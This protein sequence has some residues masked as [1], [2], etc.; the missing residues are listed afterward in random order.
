MYELRSLQG[1]NQRFIENCETKSQ[2]GREEKGSGKDKQIQ[3][4]L[5]RLAQYSAIYEGS[6]SATFEET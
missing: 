4:E 3:D 2:L 1:V 6:S 5:F